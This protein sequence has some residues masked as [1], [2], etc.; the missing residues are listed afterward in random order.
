MK[1]VRTITALRAAIQHIRSTGKQV[2]LVPTM[3]ALHHGHLSLIDVATEHAEAVVVSIFVNPTQFGAN[4]DLAHYPR[5]EA[6]DIAKLVEKNVDVVYLPSVSEMYGEHAKTIVSVK[7]VSEVLC[8]AYRKGHFDGVATVVTKLFMQ[9]QPDYA[10]F[11][12]KDFQQL[13]IIRQLVRDLDI[14]VT[15]LSAPIMREASG[16]AMSSR[17]RY[18]SEEE[19]AIASQLYR[20]LGDTRTRLLEGSAIDTTLAAAKTA[21][22]QA[23]FR[24]VDY[25]ELR[26]SE[27]LAPAEDLGKPAR[28]LVAAY[29]GATRLIDNIAI[30]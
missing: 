13:F 7:E 2:A 10:V 26:D 23:G 11:G 29:L 22:I 14:P 12:E 17:N 3:G 18:L 21:L 6:E 4:E 20:I 28:L 27:T 16:L 1:I 24:T 9:A 30:H 25:L 15:V 5:T 8:G 19:R